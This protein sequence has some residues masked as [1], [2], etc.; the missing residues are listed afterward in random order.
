MWIFLLLSPVLLTGYQGSLLPYS[1]HTK[2]C[3]FP[4]PSS[5]KDLLLT[6]HAKGCGLLLNRWQLFHVPLIYS[7]L[8][9]IPFYAH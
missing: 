2:D 4:S 6:P 9:S 8:I 5:L 7:F 1:C 3:T